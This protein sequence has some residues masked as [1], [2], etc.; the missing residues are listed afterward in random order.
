[1]LPQRDS[2]NFEPSEPQESHRE[3]ETTKS[4][5]KFDDQSTS[6][7]ARAES[8]ASG[9][10][11][12]IP[13]REDSIETLQSG[14][15]GLETYRDLRQGEKLARAKD[16]ATSENSVGLTTIRPTP[17]EVVA[18][19]DESAHSDRAHSFEDGKKPKKVHALFQKAVGKI[20]L[21]LGKLTHNEHLIERGE[22]LKAAGAAEME[23]VAEQKH[24]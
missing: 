24:H 8:S 6:Q 11:P 20:E 13:P 15:A 14:L 12:V 10:A 7:L 18:E 9:P 22:E 2:E 16:D 1:M 21:G 19:S 17:S 5:T 4:A 3:M 23:K